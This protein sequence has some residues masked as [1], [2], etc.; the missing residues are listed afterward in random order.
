MKLPRQG[1]YVVALPAEGT[2]GRTIGHAYIEREQEKTRELLWP[3]FERIE[4]TKDASAVQAL[5]KSGKYAIRPLTLPDDPWDEDK[6][7][8][9]VQQMQE[10]IEDL[11]EAV[12]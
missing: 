8:E 7:R 1:L 11:H 2:A 3:N 5:G 12:S 10:T 9:I 4:L 6:Q